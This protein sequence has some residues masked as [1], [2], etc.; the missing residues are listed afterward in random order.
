MDNVAHQLNICGVLCNSPVDFDL[1]CSESYLSEC[2]CLVLLVVGVL[3]EDSVVI[4]VLAEVS[5]P[6]RRLRKG[7]LHHRKV[8][9]ARTLRRNGGIE[10]LVYHFLSFVLNSFMPK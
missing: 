6:G 2:E 9:E 1:G 4:R 3:L 7:L 10:S 8:V 5:L